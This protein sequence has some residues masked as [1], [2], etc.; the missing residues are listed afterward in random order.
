M[1]GWHFLKND[2]RLRFGDNRLVEVGEIYSVPEDEPLRLC[3][4]GLHASRRIMDALLYAPG[5]ILCRVNLIGKRINAVDKSVAYYREVE[6]MIDS[7]DILFE[8]ARK[9]ALDVIHLWNI[10]IDYSDVVM[11]YL[12]TGNVSIRA[13]AHCAADFFVRMH[14]TTIIQERAARAAMEA[15]SAKTLPDDAIS[16]ATLAS[17]Y[18]MWTAENSGKMPNFQYKLN[19]RITSMVIA[20]HKK[21]QGES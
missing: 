15:S 18:A 5:T 6:W 19:R 12:K 7:T 9:C 4:H 16:S 13:E 3:S 1:K 2:Q 21:Q 14:S 10:G 8:F 11:K 17:K 20:K